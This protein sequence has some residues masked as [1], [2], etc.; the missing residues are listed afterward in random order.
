MSVDLVL[1][2]LTKRIVKDDPSQFQKFCVNFQRFHE[3]FLYEIIKVRQG[4]QKFCAAWILKIL[5][6]AHNE[7]NNFGI[8]SGGTTKMAM[9]FFN[10]TIRVTGDET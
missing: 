2:A 3:L 5:T 4:Y 6:G 9:N 7:G 10:C 8:F 1:K